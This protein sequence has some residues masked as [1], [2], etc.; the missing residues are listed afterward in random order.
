MDD[1]TTQIIMLAIGAGGITG[2]ITAIAAAIVTFKKLPSGIKQL[3]AE[4]I[5]TNVTADRAKA[6]IDQI[7]AN[8]QADAQRLYIETSEKGMA[9]IGRIIQ[10]QSEHIATLDA[11]VEKLR[12]QIDAQRNDFEGRINEQALD[13]STKLES[14]Q[15]IIDDLRQKLRQIQERMVLLEKENVDLKAENKELKR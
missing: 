6:D 3:D 5:V 8:I 13:F 12:K 14:Q 9:A 15:V 11:M 10:E 2:L 4:T 7:Y 1:N